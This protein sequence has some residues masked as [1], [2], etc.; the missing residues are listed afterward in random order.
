MHSSDPT[1]APLYPRLRR[2][3]GLGAAA[4]LSGTLAA[5]AWLSTILPVGG[6]FPLKALIVPVLLLVQV[7]PY[8]AEHGQPSLGPANA[9][10]LVRAGLTGVTAAFLGEPAAADLVWP[11][12]G[13]A[14][15]AFGLDWVDGR[16][17]RA[18]GRASPFGARLDMELDAL[19]ILT[20]CGFAWQLDRAGAW[21]F[22]GGALRYLFVAAAALW[23][24]MNR[25]LFPSRRR[26]FVCGVQIVCL[27]GCLAPWP[28]PHLSDAIAAFG[29][30]ALVYSFGADTVWLFRHR[31]DP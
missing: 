26:P 27:V 12:I 22:V 10:T 20:L 21:V 23:P 11:L 30:V 29:T 19:A 8:L 3:A 18:S 4:T 31:R 14:M 13:A 1:S 15:L 28:V 25:P 5:A 16:V 24:W 7:L 9:L 17:A 2:S 6:A